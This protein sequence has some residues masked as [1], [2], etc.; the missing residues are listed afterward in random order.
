MLRRQ[1][2]LAAFLSTIALAGGA[3]SAQAAIVINEIDSQPADFVELYNTG[4]AAV[5]IANWDIVDQGG[6]VSSIPNAPT[7]IAAGA[8]FVF[9]NPPGL[10]NPD[11]VTL[12]D[13]ADAT[14]DT[15]SWLDHAATTFGRCPDGTGTFI[16]TLGPTSNAANSCAANLATWPGGAG[17]ADADLLNGLPT[18]NMSGLEYIPSGSAAKGVMYAVRNNPGTL[19]RLIHNGAAWVQD[20]TNGW[21]DGKTL[22]YPLGNGNPDAE[23]VTIDAG[24]PNA[25]YVAVERDGNP[26][27]SAPRVLRYDT[28]GAAEPL[29]ATDE[30]VLS[31]PGAGDNT[32]PEAIQWIPD[33]DLVTKGFRD[34][35]L[36]KVYSPADYSNHGTGLFFVGVEFDGSIRAYALDR[37]TDTATL[38]STFSNT[39]S[40][41]MDLEYDVTTKKLFAACDDTCAGNVARMDVDGTGNFVVEQNLRRPTGMPNLN[42]EGFTIA[43]VAE[44]VGGVRPVYWLDDSSTGGHALRSGTLNC[45]GALPTVSVGTASIAEGNAGTVVLNAPVTLSAASGAEVTVKYST[46]GGTATAGSDYVGVTNGTVTIPAGQTTANAPVTVNGDTADEAASETFDV[47]LSQP[48]GATVA[49]ATATQTITDDDEAAATATPTPTATATPTPDPGPSAACKKAGAKLKSAQ[50]KLKKAEKK[51]KAKK[52]AG[53][54]LRKAKKAVKLARKAAKKAKAAKKKACA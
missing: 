38:V 16:A 44:C 46:G 15:F 17:V 30:F 43:P 31:I 24:D 11:A 36:N 10:G 5:D 47:T 33:V 9:P 29:N 19:F 18:G 49:T 42:N 22:L 12:R 48:V 8:F 45:P 23:G 2:F 53:K 39:Y 35:T 41:V 1:G 7:S 13:A 34:Q 51:L 21:A 27:P 37:T 4:P 52:A 14:V 26:A 20:A 25:V 28:T 32:G 50:A 3:A 54:P 40:A 6:N